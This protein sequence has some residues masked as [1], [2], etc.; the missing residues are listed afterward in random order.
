MWRLENIETI[1]N[2]L[3]FVVLPTET[4]SVGPDTALDPDNLF[5]SKKK[6]GCRL[7]GKSDKT[8]IERAAGVAH[9]LYYLLMKTWTLGV[10]IHPSPGSPIFKRI[11][12]TTLLSTES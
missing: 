8:R 3:F 4:T 1:P 11:F 10:K 7:E 12:F 5:A 6:M 2:K 9:L